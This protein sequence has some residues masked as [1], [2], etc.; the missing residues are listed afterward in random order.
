MLRIFELG[1]QPSKPKAFN[2]AGRANLVGSVTY[3]KGT[4]MMFAVSPED[5][6]NL[7]YLFEVYQDA[8][9]YQAHINGDYYKDYVKAE[10]TLLTN[11]KKLTLTDTQSIGEKPTQISQKN[12]ENQPI[13]RLAELVIKPESAEQSRQIVIDEMQ[14]TI[15]KESNVLA[16]YAATSREQPE[17]WFFVEVYTDEAAYQV[18]RNTSHFQKY[19]KETGEMIAERNV[20]AM[21]NRV[22]MSKGGLG[23]NWV[24]NK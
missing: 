13:V 14:Q 4:L 16:M 19:L 1:V 15:A 5:N 2:N 18:H 10:P 23:F 11:H 3:E 22:L 17:K 9:A 7:V 12:G 8:A 6:P 20:R 24:E 21:K